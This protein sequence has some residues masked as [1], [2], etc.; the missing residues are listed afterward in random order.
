MAA[1]RRVRDLSDSLAPSSVGYVVAIFVGLAV[2]PLA[3]AVYFLMA[4][5]IALPLGTFRAAR[6]RL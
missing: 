1:G 4:V 2:P 3:V 6:C 5:L